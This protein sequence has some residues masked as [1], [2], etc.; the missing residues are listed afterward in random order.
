[1]RTVEGAVRCVI[2][3]AWPWGIVVD[4]MDPD[5]TSISRRACGR[6]IDTFGGPANVEFSFMDV[7]STTEDLWLLTEAVVGASNAHVP[8]RATKVVAECRATLADGEQ[9]VGLAATIAYDV[10]V[11]AIGVP[12]TVHD[13]AR[14]LGELA[15]RRCP[16][17]VRLSFLSNE[18]GFQSTVVDGLMPAPWQVG[19]AM[20]DIGLGPAE[21]VQ[22]TE[23]VAAV[24]DGACAVDAA[25]V[26]HAVIEA[27]VGGIVGDA[28]SLGPTPDAERRALAHLRSTLCMLGVSYGPLAA[29]ARVRALWML[30]G[31]AAEC[32][33]IVVGRVRGEGG[34]LGNR[35]A[36]RLRASRR[37]RG[38]SHGRVSAWAR[39]D[40]SLATALSIPTTEEWTA[41]STGVLA[42]LVDDA[43]ADADADD[44]PLTA[45]GPL[46][47]VDLPVDGCFDMLQYAA[48]TIIEDALF[49]VV[50]PPTLYAR[51]EVVVSAVRMAVATVVVENPVVASLFANPMAVAESVLG[52][53]L[54]ISGAPPGTWAG[55]TFLRDHAAPDQANGVFSS[56][57]EHIRD[58][59]RDWVSVIFAELGQTCDAR[60]IRDASEP[61]GYYLYPHNCVVLMLGLLHMPLADEAYDDETILSRIGFVIAHELA[62]ASMSHARLADGYDYVLEHYAS[63]T[64]EEALADVVAMVALTHLR[65]DR[66][67]DMLL[68]VGQVFCRS[69]GEE[70]APPVGATGLHPSGNSRGNALARTMYEKFGLVCGGWT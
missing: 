12:Q 54:R 30:R 28:R 32:V 63:K 67:E 61:N 19:E 7:G 10:L 18:H 52:T 41:V 42:R 38:P 13:V 39:S 3:W 44:A 31:L 51:L 9:R 24:A 37:R 36:R 16:G 58:E 11:E 55:R 1:M 25:D 29:E 46:A 56:V 59:T 27:V 64:R 62:H 33:A 34:V 53:R 49:F 2:Q 14:G 40:A 21:V 8:G 68:H 26:P 47:V 4:A 23:A 17:P 45:D 66:C 22:A 57:L 43:D 69:V 6:W 5:A 60:P 15:A 65:P 50:V 35:G 48:I 20:G 70:G